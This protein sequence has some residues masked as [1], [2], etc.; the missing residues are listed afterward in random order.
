MRMFSEFIMQYFI[1]LKGQMRFQSVLDSFWTTLSKYP[2]KLKYVF[3]V[4]E[5]FD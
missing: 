2:F 5:V 3:I 4:E 1:V